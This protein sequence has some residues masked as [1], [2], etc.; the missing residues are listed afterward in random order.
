MKTIVILDDQ[1]G[2]T[3]GMEGILQRHGF[4]IFPVSTAGEAAAIAG[5]PGITIDLLIAGLTLPGNTTARQLHESC[6]E[7]PLLLVSESALEQ[8]PETDFLYF[9]SL[10]SR[11]DFLRK[12]LKAA[13]FVSRINSLLYNSTYTAGRQIFEAAAA[14][15]LQQVQE[16]A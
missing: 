16:V 11:T 5:R 15:R 2:S 6:P 12:P 13:A 14:L 10:S 1:P 9:K 4:V 7:I 8:W 3:Q